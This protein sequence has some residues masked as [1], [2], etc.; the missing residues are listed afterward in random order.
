MFGL[1]DPCRGIMPAPTLPVITATLILAACQSADRSSRA[2][3]AD[4]E[5]GFAPYRASFAAAA[6]D[7]LVEQLDREELLRRIT[8]SGALWLGDHHRHARLH[9]LQSELLDAL[10]AADAALTLGLEAVGVQDQEWVDDYLAGRVDMATLRR[11][12]RTRWPGSWLD[13]PDLD[14][15]YFRSLLRFARAHG[16]PVLALE[17]TPRLPLARRDEVMARAVAAARRAHPD[18]V[19]VVLVGQAH[20]LGRGDLVRRSGVGGVVIGGEPTDAL[21]RVRPPRGD[22]GSAWRSNADV[23]WFSPMFQR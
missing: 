4:R 22:A 19:L 11:R 17:P 12:M 15:F 23:Y 3:P 6:G 7:A 10:A 20:L 1:E 5:D 9:A 14:P 16:V 2:S 18:R 8:S 13:D 21:Q